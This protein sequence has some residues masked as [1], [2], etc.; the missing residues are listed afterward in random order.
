[1]V[2]MNLRSYRV[3]ISPAPLLIKAMSVWYVLS[4]VV[5]RGACDHWGRWGSLDSFHT[6]YFIHKFHGM[7]GRREGAGG[8]MDEIGIAA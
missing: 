2:C 7:G 1:M 4:F 8:A 5:Q 3:D 6:A